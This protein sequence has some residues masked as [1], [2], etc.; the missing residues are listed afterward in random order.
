MLEIPPVQ[1]PAVTTDEF[2]EAYPAH[3]PSRPGRTDRDSALDMLRRLDKPDLVELR[4]EMVRLIN[5]KT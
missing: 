2:L 1:V 5:E 4:K 3:V